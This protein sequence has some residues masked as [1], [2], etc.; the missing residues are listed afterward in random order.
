MQYSV[1][2]SDTKFTAIWGVMTQIRILLVDDH[3]LWRVG[4]RALIERNREFAISA[5]ASSAEEALAQAKIVQPDVILLDVNLPERDGISICKDLLVQN[6][7]HRILMLTGSAD[8]N[9]VIDAIIAGAKGYILKDADPK[10]L[11][12]AVKSVYADGSYIDPLL[13]PL[14]FEQIRQRIMPSLFD[15]LTKSEKQVLECMTQG[16]TN[17]D[18]AQTLGLSSGTVRNYVSAIFKKLGVNNRI[19]A[20][21]LAI[22]ERFTVTHRWPNCHIILVTGDT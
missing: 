10:E 22:R 16:Q 9:F 15:D 8:K 4:L 6:P 14:L 5:E 21:K 11:L 18:I 12:A 7:F 13:T 3:Q 1:G 20:S 17:K 19:D 2:N